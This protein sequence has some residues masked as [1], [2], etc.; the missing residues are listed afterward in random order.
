MA[1]TNTPPKYY[2]KWDDEKRQR[3]SDYLERGYSYAKTAQELNKLY[4]EHNFSLESIRYQKRSGCLTINARKPLNPNRTLRN[5]QI[6]EPNLEKEKEDYTNPYEK[7][8][9]EGHNFEV[10]GNYSILDYRG[11]ENPSTLD[12][13][14]ASC[15]VDTGVWEVERYVVNKWEVAMKV[16]GPPP[17]IIHRPLFQIKAWLCRLVPTVVE[18]PTIKTIQPILYKAPKRKY[19][20]T[21][22]KRRKNIYF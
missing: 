14:L 6:V 8:L 2:V 18:F 12:E 1:K 11:E 19:K 20:K 7:E 5:K 21:R 13:L 15:D 16:A 3:C 17:T 10:F 4:P 9:D 22:E